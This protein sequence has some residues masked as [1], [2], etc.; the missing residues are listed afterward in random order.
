VENIMKM[1]WGL[2]KDQGGVRLKSKIMEQ[3]FLGQKQKQRRITGKFPPSLR[4]GRGEL[5]LIGIN[6][7]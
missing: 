3:I 2:I 5:I 7:G 4:R 6:P 1:G